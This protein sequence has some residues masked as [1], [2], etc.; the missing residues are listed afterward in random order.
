ME[1]RKVFFF[2]NNFIY[3]F[4][5]LL[6]LRHQ[7]GFSLVPASEGHSVVGV[8]RPLLARSTQAV[9]H[10]AFGS[11]GSVFSSCSSQAPEHRLSRCGPWA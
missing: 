2:L 6:G 8:L 10:A 5:A 3:L 4:L 11:C 9:G 7:E 1:S